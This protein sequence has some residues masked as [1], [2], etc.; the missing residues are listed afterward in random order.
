MHINLLYGRQKQIEPTHL[1]NTFFKNKHPVKFLTKS[2]ESICHNIF[3][4][5][6]KYIFTIILTH[7]YLLSNGNIALL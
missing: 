1:I 5:W 4:Q 7:N 2:Y 3:A 6:K